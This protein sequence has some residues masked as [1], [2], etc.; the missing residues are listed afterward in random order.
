MSS[1]DV[2]S[3][4]NLPHAGPSSQQSRKQTFKRPDGIS[5]E[6]YALIGDNAP[7]LLDV[8][9]SVS[10]VKY[11]EKPKTK[12]PAAKWQVETLGLADIRAWKMFTPAARGEEAARLGHWV[13]ELDEPQASGEADSRCR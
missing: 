3:I 2:R 9:A 8:Q 6:L 13:R 12:G 10:A 5:R 11:R 4:L 1:S 7:S